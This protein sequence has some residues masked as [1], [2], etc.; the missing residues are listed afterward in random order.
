MFFSPY[1]ESGVKT[2]DT[3]KLLSSSPLRMLLA[4]QDVPF[5][6]VQ[7]CPPTSLPEPALAPL[8]PLPRLQAPPLSP[9]W[10]LSRASDPHIHSLRCPTGTWDISKPELISHPHLQSAPPPSVPFQRMPC[11]LFIYPAVPARNLGGTP[12]SVSSALSHSTS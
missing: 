5:L 1:S 6:G 11:H 2:Q 12:D 3:S 8:H 10:N 7:G 4:P 9:H